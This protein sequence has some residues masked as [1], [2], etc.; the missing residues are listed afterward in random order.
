MSGV[1]RVRYRA[2]FISPHLDDAVFSC[3]GHISR[4]AKEGPVLVLNLF[5]RYLSN[6]K[7]RGVVLGEE[8]YKEEADAAAFLG[9]ESR[10]LGELDVSFRR[11]AYKQ[12]GNIFR[13]PIA[14]DVEW[15]PELR[16]KVFSVLEP[17][18]YQEIY[19]PLGVGWHVD[20][21][22]TYLLFEQW[23]GSAA[24]FYYEDAPYCCIPHSTRYRLD[25]IARYQPDAHDKS[26]AATNELRAWWQASMGY[27]ETALMKNL[28]PWIVRIFA[29][30]VVSFYLYRLM[31][32][33]RKMA[34]K[35]PKQP[36]VPLTRTEQ[37]VD[38]FDMKVNAMGI[39]HSQFQEFFASPEDCLSTLQRYGHLRQDGAELSER[40]WVRQ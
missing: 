33:H 37:R 16:Q 17:L 12:L 23:T 13:P 6:V 39:Y 3:G 28:R 11:D 10:S 5:S 21:V 2:I 14:E 31:S 27:A 20:H 40:L 32:M 36:M 4:L 29:V 18:D 1:E 26:L 7:N 15:L 25:E 22:L 35:S 38:W 8:R 24:M 30:P 34:R 9:F 19:V